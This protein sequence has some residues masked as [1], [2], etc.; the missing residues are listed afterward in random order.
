M[1]AMAHISTP[2][3][4]QAAAVPIIKKR[5]TTARTEYVSIFMIERILF[6]VIIGVYCLHV[7]IV[8]KHVQRLGQIGY[9]LL[10]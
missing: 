10:G 2:L 7:V 4:P 5:I 9:I 6:L 1:R 8:V 3:I